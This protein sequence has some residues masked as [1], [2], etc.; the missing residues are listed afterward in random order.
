MHLFTMPPAPR[1]LLLTLNTR[2]AGHFSRSTRLPPYCARD[3]TLCLLARRRHRPPYCSIFLSHTYALPALLIVWPTVRGFV[4]RLVYPS[5]TGAP[6][7]CRERWGGYPISIRLP[8]VSPLPARPNFTALP[9][10][11]TCRQTTA[12][13]GVYQR[14]DQ[15][16]PSFLL[17]C[18]F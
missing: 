12:L 13:P 11:A 15:P 4:T 2:G 6:G 9:F 14:R 17:N 3:C 5:L 7:P 10:F 8:F 1:Y 16:Y 18:E